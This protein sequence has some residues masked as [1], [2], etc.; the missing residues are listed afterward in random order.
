MAMR[1]YVLHDDEPSLETEEKIDIGLY[2]RHGSLHLRFTWQGKQHKVNLHQPDNK[3]NRAAAILLLA[4]VKRDIEIGSFIW[5]QH[6]DPKGTSLS[7]L[8]GY[9]EQKWEKTFPLFAKA[10]RRNYTSTMSF[11]IS[12]FGN[13]QLSSITPSDITIALVEHKTN[14]GKLLSPHSYNNYKSVLSSM[15][16]AALGDK[17]VQSNPCAGIKKQKLAPAELRINPFEKEEAKNILVYFMSKDEQ[18]HNYFAFQFAC[19]LRP[20]EAIALKWSDIDFKKR[21]VRV[22]QALVEGEIGDTKT[23]ASVRDV[24]LTD[25]ALSILASQKKHS[26]LKGDTVFLNPETGKAWSSPEKLRRNNWNPCLKKL[27]ILHRSPYNCRH[28][29]ASWMLTDGIP[30]GYVSKQLGHASIATTLAHY[31]KWMDSGNSE[32]LK[33][34]NQLVGLV[35]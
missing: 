33:K 8:A 20:S 6:F 11:W 4:K 17:L 28:S 27:G 5:E 24:D 13:R 32:V 25:Y 34:R 26:F 16:R 31:A 23:V 1:T 35:S 10:T 7:T 15:F 12:V 22:V 2:V 3:T 19:G 9:Y 14:K 30:I 21:I 29:Y 18:I